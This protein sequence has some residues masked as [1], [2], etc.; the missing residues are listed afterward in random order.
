[1]M[2]LYLT[3]VWVCQQDSYKTG[4]DASI[5]LLSYTESRRCFSHTANIRLS[6]FLAA[7]RP[8]QRVYFFPAEVV[9]AALVAPHGAENHAPFSMTKSR[10]TKKPVVLQVKR[11][12]LRFPTDSICGQM[13]N[14]TLLSIP[15]RCNLLILAQGRCVRV[16]L[17]QKLMHFLTMVCTCNLGRAPLITQRLF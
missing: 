15:N 4:S 12:L 13:D 2:S 16:K 1:M 11:T 9:D 14:L 6:S 17:K 5:Y 3:L 8:Y 10:R 7:A